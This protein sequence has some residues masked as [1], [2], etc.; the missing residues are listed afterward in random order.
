MM[1]AIL[2]LIFWFT[3]KPHDCT[4]FIVPEVDSSSY[5][6]NGAYSQVTCH[7]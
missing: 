6:V 4:F 7:Y 3:E 5:E 2:A 1:G